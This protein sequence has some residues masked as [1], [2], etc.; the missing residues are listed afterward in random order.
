MP[1]HNYVVKHEDLFLLG[2]LHDTAV[3]TSN[4]EKAIHYSKKSAAQQAGS[5]EGAFA[6]EDIT[7][8]T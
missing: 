3:W 4:I 6:Y 2:F 7:R 1:K 5:W 8:R